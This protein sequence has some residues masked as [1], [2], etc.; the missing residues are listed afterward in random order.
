ML[1]IE[2]CSCVGVHYLKKGGTI[3]LWRKRVDE[4]ALSLVLLILLLFGLLAACAG[5]PSAPDPAGTSTQDPPIP[6]LTE[7][8]HGIMDMTGTIPQ[9]LLEQLRSRSD[10][11]QAHG[12]QIA[13]VFFNDLASD[14]HQFATDV[15]NK[16]GIGFKDT[17]NGVL[18]VLYLQ[19]PGKDGHAPWLTYITGGGI[20]AALPDTLM[21]DYA[22]TTFV[23]T[24]AQGQWQEGL[25]AF[26]D[27]VYA[28]ERDPSV[29]QE[30]QT[31]HPKSSTETSPSG[32]TNSGPDPAVV[33]IFVSIAIS[34][35]LMISA[36]V[37]ARR[38]ENFFYTAIR[39]LGRFLLVLAIIS[40][41]T[42][43]GSPSGNRGSWGGGGAGHWGG[44]G[45]SP[46]SG[47]DG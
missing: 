24:R 34:V 43:R 41:N 27:R 31:T 46:S 33:F 26:Y 8:T 20:S 1:K 10:D 22:Q 37:A 36:A 7:A 35:W 45:S 38:R 25:L 14:P 9:S 28:A 40:R 12:Y 4:K 47:G 42:S 30:W 21:D 13:V 23:P 19:K 29:A 15:F 2:T 44:G 11:V 3:M 16:N 5:Q 18:F 6:Q 32:N 17:N 39:L